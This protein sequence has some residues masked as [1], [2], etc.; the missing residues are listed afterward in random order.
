[1]TGNLLKPRAYHT[2]TA[3]PSGKVLVAAGFDFTLLNTAELYDP[4]TASWTNTGSLRLARSDHT[5]TILPSGKV[6]VVGGLL[7]TNYSTDSAELYDPTTGKWTSTGSL[8][9]ARY[10]H[11]A[12]LLASG[13]VLVAAGQ[14]GYASCCDGF[15]QSAEVYDPATGVWTP[16]GDLPVPR[17][18]HTAT[19]LPSGKVLVAAGL[20]RQYSDGAELFDPSTGAWTATD[21]LITRRSRHTATLLPS[22]DVLV[23]GGDSD[24]LSSRNSL[25]TAEIYRSGSSD[26]SN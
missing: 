15:L 26:A 21:S 18:Q 5:A 17:V 10:R 13:Q 1:M 14:G 3:L 19:L 24:T 6:L 9:T 4:A 22:G 23:A 16:V 12:T 8:H 20:N 7:D 25:R 2:A 11:T